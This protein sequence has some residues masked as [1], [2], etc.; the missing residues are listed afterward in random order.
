MEKDNGYFR[1]SYIQNTD[2]LINEGV[3]DVLLYD[4]IFTEE[5]KFSIVTYTYG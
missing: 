2:K 3:N 5:T 1:K 4:N